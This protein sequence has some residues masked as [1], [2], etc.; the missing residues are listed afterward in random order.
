VLLAAPPR[1]F[2]AL[3][4]PAA[5]TMWWN[6]DDAVVIAAAWQCSLQPPCLHLCPPTPQ[7]SAVPP[8]HRWFPEGKVVFVAPTRPLVTQQR[9]ACRKIMGM[10]QV[11]GFLLACSALYQRR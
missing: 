4:P 5:L 7:Q 1:A 3:Q 11:G 8:I 6:E 2:S 9:E 10:A